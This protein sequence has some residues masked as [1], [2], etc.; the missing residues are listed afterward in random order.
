MNDLVDRLK[1]P[2]DNYENLDDAQQDMRLAASKLTELLLVIDQRNGELTGRLRDCKFNDN[3]YWRTRK[4][5]EDAASK[6]EQAER[7][8][9]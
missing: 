3:G 2:F 7:I 6:L 1:N 4:V 9:K 8:L 5:C